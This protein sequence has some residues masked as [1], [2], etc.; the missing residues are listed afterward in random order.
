MLRNP[1]PSDGNDSHITLLLLLAGFLLTRG[2]PILT[3][4][5]LS[6]L[7]TFL[8]DHNKL[9]I[10]VS[11]INLSPVYFKGPRTRRVICYELLRG[12][13]LLSQ[14]SRC[15]SPK[16]PLLTLSQY[17]GALTTIRVVSLSDQGL[18]PQPRFQ[19]SAMIMGLE[20]DRIVRNF[21]PG[22]LNQCSTP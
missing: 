6:S 5:L 1:C 21:F 14:P 10:V 3:K 11:A 7:Y 18:T 20:F 2:P 13:L 19:P 22:L 4:K 9:C 12:W 15:L 8:L 17:F 16:T